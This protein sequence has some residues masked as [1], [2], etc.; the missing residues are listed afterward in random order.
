MG[1]L[2]PFARVSALVGDLE[3]WRSRSFEA[4]AGSRY[5]VIEDFQLGGE[6]RVVRAAEFSPAFS[7][8]SQVVLATR[9]FF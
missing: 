4:I 7:N 8:E 3:F 2:E 9:Y 5:H 1:D 6:L